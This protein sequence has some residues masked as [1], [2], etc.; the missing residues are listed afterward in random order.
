M[1][2]KWVFFADLQLETNLPDF[3]LLVSPVEIVG[4]LCPAMAPKK[5]TTSTFNKFLVIGLVFAGFCVGMLCQ[6]QMSIG[7]GRP[8]DMMQL[9]EEA[10]QGD[11]QGISNPIPI[12]KPIMAS[13]DSKPVDT[14]DTPLDP[15]PP[16]D[17]ADIPDTVAEVGEVPPPDE[18]PEPSSISSSELKPASSLDSLPSLRR[19]PLEEPKVAPKIGNTSIERRVGCNHCCNDGTKNGPCFD[20]EECASGVTGGRYAFVY[21][22]VGDPG[23]PWLTFLDSMW[24][25]A[26]KLEEIGGVA[27]IVVL[28]PGENI[29]NLGCQHRRLVEQYR[30]RIIEVPWTIPP[31]SWYPSYWWPGKADGWCGPQD[32]MRL[33]ALGLDDYDAVVFYVAWHRP[34]LQ[35]KQLLMAAFSNLMI[36]KIL[37]WTYCMAFKQL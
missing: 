4:I 13:P 24:A 9:F 5:K 30:L 8:P 28:M 36:L 19:Q 16:P 23:W 33:H 1:Q 12:A 29:R 7:K 3:L 6:S 35:Q 26:V 14:V 11:Q 18:R 32:L 34:S 31:N 17:T 37:Y 21:A 15:D 25:Q 20:V 10:A 2:F 27:D 22:H